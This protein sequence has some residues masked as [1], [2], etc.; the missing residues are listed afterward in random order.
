M[1]TKHWWIYTDKGEENSMEKNP[2][3]S[4]FV[5]QKSDT[6]WPGVEP[7]LCSD[8]PETNHLGHSKVRL[9]SDN[10]MT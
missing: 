5:H 7:D 4:Q 3:Q 9:P 8:G 6:D 2:S 1:S 10:V